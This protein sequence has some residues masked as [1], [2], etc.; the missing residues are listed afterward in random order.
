M[1]SAHLSDLIAAAVARLQANM[2]ESAPFMAGQVAA[3]FKHLS[4]P[5]D[6]K[7]YFQHPQAFPALLLPGWL[8]QASR[9]EPDRAFQAD[10]AYSTISGYYAI[11]LMD[12]LMDGHATIELKLLPALNFFQTEFQRPYQGYFGFDHPF[13]DVFRR[14]WFYS[15]EVTIRDAGLTGID[16]ATFEQVSAQ[17]VCAAKIPIAAVCYRYERPDLIEPWFRLVD[18][19][20]CWHQFLNDLFGWHR[21]YARRTCTYFLSEAERQRLDDEPVAGWIT[22]AGFAWAIAQ[23]GGWLAALQALAEELDSPDLTTYLTTRETMLQQ[24]QAEVAA[25]LQSLAR[26][27]ATQRTHTPH[28]P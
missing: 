7:D 15:A 4:G 3:W 2:A 28:L 17:K 12:N 25:G 21:D 10:L 19:L 14:I 24:Q 16:Q 9:V 22:R 18:L 20:G 1:Y 26:L 11:R 6:P 13:W 23:A 8:E 27:M 5:L